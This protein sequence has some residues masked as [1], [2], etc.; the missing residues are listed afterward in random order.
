MNR[1]LISAALLL[2]ISPLW[3]IEFPRTTR[4]YVGTASY[5]AVVEIE[6]VV[7]APGGKNLVQYRLSVLEEWKGNLPAVIDIRIFSASRVIQPSPVL[8]GPGS[9]WVVFLGNPTGE[10]YYPLKSLHWG[11]IELLE[12]S[13][14]NYWL[15]R[16]VTGF[17]QAYEGKRLSLDQF[18]SLVKGNR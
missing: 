15:A 3:S 18:R 14:G 12:D 1:T 9:R 8:E 6:N 7:A 16:P 5:I 11:K 10:G 13:N 17:G 4:D 2:L